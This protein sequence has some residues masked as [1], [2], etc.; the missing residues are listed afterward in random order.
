MLLLEPVDLARRHSR[1]RDPAVRPRTSGRSR[2]TASAIAQQPLDAG[3]VDAGVFDEVLDQ[4]SR[5]S[6]SRE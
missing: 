5:S 1:R 4:P 2:C 3:E 6:S